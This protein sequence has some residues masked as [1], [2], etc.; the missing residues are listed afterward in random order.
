MPSR[1]SEPPNVEII[2]NREELDGIEDLVLFRY[3]LHTPFK[4]TPSSGWGDRFLTPHRAQM[5]GSRCHNQAAVITAMSPTQLSFPAMGAAEGKG[6][7][8]VAP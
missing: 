2:V 5:S 8:I 3:R 7:A 1:G 4:T 6:V